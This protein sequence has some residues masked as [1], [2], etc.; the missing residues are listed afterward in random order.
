MTLLEAIV[1][2][3]YGIFLFLIIVFLIIFLI[4]E[5]KKK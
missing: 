3:I 1:T 2:F 4:K 5:L